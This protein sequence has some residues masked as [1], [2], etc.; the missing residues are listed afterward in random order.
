MIAL[1]VV[2]MQF[3]QTQTQQTLSRGHALQ[4]DGFTVTYQDL[5]QYQAADG[6]QV[7]QAILNVARNDRSLTTLNPRSEY[8]PLYQQSVTVPG[9][10]SNL[11]EDLYVVLVDWR[12]AS[13]ETATFHVYH[14]PLINWLWIGAAVMVLGAIV[15]I[16]IPGKKRVENV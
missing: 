1:G 4:I 10:M 2:G 3:Y 7:T 13:T 15:A 16:G 6:R 5:I 11:A 8:Y 12:P 14:N 9:R